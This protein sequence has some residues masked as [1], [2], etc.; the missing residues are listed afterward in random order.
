MSFATKT[1]N[2]FQIIV[3]DSLSVKEGLGIPEV[4]LSSISQAAIRNI[5][6]VRAP[7]QLELDVMD[8]SEIKPHEIIDST[9]LAIFR[10]HKSLERAVLRAM[11]KLDPLAE[12]RARSYR[13]P[14]P[15]KMYN[16]QN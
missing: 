10:N 4:D 16:S 12:L 2:P 11:E 3:V 5:E 6:R 13:P 9:S 7:Q 15:T 14:A 8:T 1:I